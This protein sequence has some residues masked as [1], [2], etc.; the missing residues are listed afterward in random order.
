MFNWKAPYLSNPVIKDAIKHRHILV[1]RNGK[2]LDG[3][4]IEVNKD[5]V[6]QLINEVQSLAKE[7]H[8]NIISCEKGE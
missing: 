4:T 5:R 8:S 3:S 6:S 7:I 2:R 1:H